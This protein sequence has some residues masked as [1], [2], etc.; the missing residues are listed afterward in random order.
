MKI[1]CFISTQP[2]TQEFAYLVVFVNLDLLSILIIFVCF[3]LS[4]YQRCP[5][6]S[7]VLKYLNAHNVNMLNQIPNVNASS[8][9]SILPYNPFNSKVLSPT[10]PHS[11][12]MY[13]NWIDL[14]AKT[15]DQT[16]YLFCLQ[17]NF[18]VHSILLL[19][20]RICGV[21][22][23]S[24]Y[25]YWFHLGIPQNLALFRLY[26]TNCMVFC[27]FRYILKA[28]YCNSPRI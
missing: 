17:G 26:L 2:T 19:C 28:I 8:A 13:A 6:T 1:R 24:S 15:P 11:H 10:T 3:T 23:T 5:D 7:T 4:Y 9:S 20:S 21:F 18:L 16:N 14:H 22:L 12:F 25:L 27:L